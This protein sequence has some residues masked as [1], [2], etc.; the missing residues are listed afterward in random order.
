MLQH[1]LSKQ[2]PLPA[3]RAVG[4]LEIVMMIDIRGAS[5]TKAR[6]RRW[7][8]AYLFLRRMRRFLHFAIRATQLVFT[9]VETGRGPLLVR[10]SS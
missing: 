2:T 3:P 7:R 8:G 9:D 6:E 1:C 5:S 4:E 10:K